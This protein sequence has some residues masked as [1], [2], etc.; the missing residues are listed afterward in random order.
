M[1]PDLVG[2]YWTGSLTLKI[3]FNISDTHQIHSK[4]NYKGISIYRVRSGKIV[5]IWHVIDGLTV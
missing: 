4:I 5:E 3:S 1:Y 2:A